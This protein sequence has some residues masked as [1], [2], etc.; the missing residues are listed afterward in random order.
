MKGVFTAGRRM[1]ELL[2]LI[3]DSLIPVCASRLTQAV[4]QMPN[5]V[6]CSCGQCLV[7]LWRTVGCT[8]VM[9]ASTSKSSSVHKVIYV[10]CGVRSFVYSFV[11]APGLKE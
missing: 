7:S 10:H 3:W 2:H 9:P 4:F 11:R 5:L 8:T 1:G 6:G